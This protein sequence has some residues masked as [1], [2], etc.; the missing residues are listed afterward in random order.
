MS[1]SNIAQD[2]MPFLEKV[3]R[4]GNLQDI[5][6]ARDLSEVVYRTMRDLM[7]KNTIERVSS[8]LDKPTIYTEDKTL[9]DGISDLWEDRNPI[10]SWLSK[11]RPPF[12]SSGILGIDEERFITRIEQEGGMPN[13]TKGET[14]VKAVFSATK[15]E[16]SL[17]RIQEIAEFLPGKIKELWNEA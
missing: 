10:V 7:P 1:T 14:V 3:M 16:L 6:E 15:D 4:A 8:E 5:Y 17:E 9:Q 11:I 13:S 2:S 12:S